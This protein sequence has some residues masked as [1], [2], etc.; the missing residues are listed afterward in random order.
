MYLD[1]GV[2]IH[3]VIDRTHISVLH[4]AIQMNLAIQMKRCKDKN[5]TWPTTKHLINAKYHVCGLGKTV[6]VRAE[7]VFD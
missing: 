5:P 3:S 7:Q 6:A 1:L 2:N 4:S